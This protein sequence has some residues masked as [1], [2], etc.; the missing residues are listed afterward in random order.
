MDMATTKLNQA[1]R[2]MASSGVAGGGEGNVM[3][4]I[5]R[6]R[7]GEEIAQGN[8]G[9][10]QFGV[11]KGLNIIGKGKEFTDTGSQYT[12]GANEAYAQ[13]RAQ[14]AANI[15]GLTQQFLAPGLG[16]VSRGFEGLLGK[17]GASVGNLFNSAGGGGAPPS[18]AINPV[19]YQP[20]TSIG[21]NTA[22]NLGYGQGGGVMGYTPNLSIG[23]GYYNPFGID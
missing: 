22:Q 21:Y 12:S 17:A 15:A 16:M 5:L 2:H 4:Q 9:I 23:S 19:G 18:S 14:N 7:A 10:E 8:L 13:Q 20:R 6:S 1:R 3:S 11:D